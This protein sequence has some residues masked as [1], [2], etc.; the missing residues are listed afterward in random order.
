MASIFLPVLLAVVNPEV[1]LAQ[2]A[3]LAL[4]VEHPSLLQAS[5]QVVA[6]AVL[7]V[8]PLVVP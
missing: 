5:L 2:L 6:L 7:A 4:V 1:H 8:V 3:V